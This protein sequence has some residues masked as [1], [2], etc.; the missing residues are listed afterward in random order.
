M[1]NYNSVI[2]AKPR[3]GEGGGE[4]G[5]TSLEFAVGSGEEEQALTGHVSWGS[6]K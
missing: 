1:S 2:P 3:W 5:S 6:P 4:S